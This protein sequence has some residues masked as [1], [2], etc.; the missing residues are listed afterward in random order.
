MSVRTI[1]RVAGVVA[2]IGWVAVV[3]IRGAV[4]EQGPTAAPSSKVMPKYDAS[5]NL[6]L[7]SDYRTWVLAG[8]SLGLSYA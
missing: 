2:V 8:S 3:A 7:P 5:K 4:L 1:G 6:V